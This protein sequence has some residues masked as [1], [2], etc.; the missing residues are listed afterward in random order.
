[1]HFPCFLLKNKKADTRGAGASLVYSFCPLPLIAL[2]YT[3]CCGVAIVKLLYDDIFRTPV[4][5]LRIAVLFQYRQF[6]T[7]SRELSLQV[8]WFPG[9]CG[10]ILRD[11]RFE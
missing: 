9:D 11:S 10:V 8:A 5:F 1:M 2:L 6:H 4:R 7:P 3:I